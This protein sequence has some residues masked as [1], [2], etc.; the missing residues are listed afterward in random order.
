MPEEECEERTEKPE[1]PFGYLLRGSE[2]TAAKCKRL[3]GIF[4]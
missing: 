1:T 3:G 2:N 4:S